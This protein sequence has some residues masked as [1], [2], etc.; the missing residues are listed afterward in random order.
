MLGLIRATLRTKASLALAASP[1]EASL[2]GASRAAPAALSP[3]L[4]GSAA[5]AGGPSAL[6]QATPIH[7]QLRGSRYPSYGGKRLPGYI[8]PKQS[9]PTAILKKM[10]KMKFFRLKR[11]KAGQRPR[12]PGYGR[13]DGCISKMNI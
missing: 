6:A 5:A 4:C 1:L 7:Q 12:P 13:Q 11:G 8:L 9:E 3:F 10:L 2:V